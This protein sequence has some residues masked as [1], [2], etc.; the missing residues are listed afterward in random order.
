LLRP[1]VTD[2]QDKYSVLFDNMNL[3]DLKIIVCYRRSTDIGISVQARLPRFFQTLTVGE[4]EEVEGWIHKLMG[5]LEEK[6][7]NYKN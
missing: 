7:I 6:A 3:G 2:K 4:L 1:E 5:E